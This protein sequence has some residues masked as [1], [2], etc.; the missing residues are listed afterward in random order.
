MAETFS[1]WLF[2][3]HNEQADTTSSAAVLL[4]D[5]CIANKPISPANR[6]SGSTRE[7]LKAW[8]QLRKQNLSTW[9]HRGTGCRLLIATQNQ[10]TRIAGKPT[11][12]GSY[13]RPFWSAPPLNYTDKPPQ[14]LWRQVILHGLVS[15]C[16]QIVSSFTLSLFSC[17]NWHCFIDLR[18]HHCC[19]VEREAQDLLRVKE[20]THAADRWHRSGHP[21]ES[22]EGWPPA[23]GHHFPY[24]QGRDLAMPF[25]LRMDRLS[26]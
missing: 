7:P 23:S 26:N 17:R 16:G 11:Q 25:C 14:H 24:P 6:S 4:C 9:D 8:L 12:Y 1:M 5:I 21:K 19:P 3:Q 13:T 20:D 15:C 10:P 22:G 18:R 2:K